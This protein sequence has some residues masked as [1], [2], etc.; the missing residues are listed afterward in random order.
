MVTMTDRTTIQ[1]HADVSLTT[2]DGPPIV[3][4]FLDDEEV[5]TLAT[6][7]SGTVALF[8]DTDTDRKR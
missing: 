2:D 3:I 5:V 1:R 8:E 7:D 6:R 4:G